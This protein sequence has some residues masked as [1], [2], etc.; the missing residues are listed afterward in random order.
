MAA[1]SPL[2]CLRQPPGGPHSPLD[3]R[4]CRTRRSGTTRSSQVSRADRTPARRLGPACAGR[5][6]PPGSAPRG[7]RWP[8]ARTAV[9][10]PGALGE[11]QAAGETVAGIDRPVAT[12][13]AS[14]DRV[15][16]DAVRTLGAGAGASGAGAGAASASGA[17]AGSSAAGP[18][19]QD[20]ALPPR[21]RRLSCLRCG[22]FSCLVSGC[23]LLR[24]GSVGSGAEGCVH[25]PGLTFRVGAGDERRRRRRDERPCDAG[26]DERLVDGLQYRSFRGARAPKQA[27][28]CGPGA[29]LRR[30]W[31]FE[32]CRVV[33]ARQRGH[34]LPDGSLSRRLGGGCRRPQ[35]HSHA[36]SVDSIFVCPSRAE[37][38]RTRLD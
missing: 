15:P 18:A 35:P 7:W 13:L 8:G 2:Y 33:P 37:K 1:R 26:D 32:T 9:G 21:G 29:W 30:R 6:R 38:D 25:V 36:G 28:G 23:K 19:P 5:S 14:R 3:R 27:H 31:C 16:V 22:S 24:S 34:D 12:G 10:P 4:W 20:Q 11:L 17:G